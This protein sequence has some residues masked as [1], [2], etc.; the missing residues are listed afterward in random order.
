MPFQ[1]FDIVEEA[2]LNPPRDLAFVGSLACPAA[3]H[4]LLATGAI[5]LSSIRQVKASF[6]AYHL[7]ESLRLLQEN[8]KKGTD[9][10]HMKERIGAAAALTSAEVRDTRFL[11]P[12]LGQIVLLRD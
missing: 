6:I 1:E 7:A 9:P 2:C 12:C 3:F 5:H 11:K 10:I 8:M 4:A